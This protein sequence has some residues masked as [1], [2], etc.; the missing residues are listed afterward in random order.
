MKRARFSIAS[1]RWIQT[2]STFPIMSCQVFPTS[3]WPGF[4]HDVHLAEQH[5]ER[6]FSMAVRSGS[7]YLRT[8]ATACRGLSHFVAGR[9][10]AAVE[11]LS[12]AIDFARRRKAGLEYEPKMLADL[13]NAYLLKGDLSAA[14]RAADEAIAVC[15]ARHAKATE[16]LARIIRA[17]TL[18]A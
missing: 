12:A 5:A 6:A 16:S 9:S 7:P 13:A 17:Q 18:L 10:G 3:I 2:T 11:D 1:S 8:Y 14:L 15:A 4:E